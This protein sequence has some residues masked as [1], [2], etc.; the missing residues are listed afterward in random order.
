M[1]FLCTK[2][3]KSKVEFQRIFVWNLKHIFSAQRGNFAFL[4]LTSTKWFVSS[5]F[6][7]Y[8]GVKYNLYLTGERAWV[9][10]H[11]C[12]CTRAR[13]RVCVHE[14]AFTSLRLRVC[15][16]KCALASM[17]PWVCVFEWTC[18]SRRARV[19]VRECAW[20][21]VRARVCSRACVHKPVHEWAC[22]RVRAWV[23]VHACDCVCESKYATDCAY[24]PARVCGCVRMCINWYSDMSVH[25][26]SRVHMG[27]CAHDECVWA[28]EC[29]CASVV[30]ECTYMCVSTCMLAWANAS[31]TAFG[32][33]GPS[34]VW[35]C[36][37]VK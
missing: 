22:T 1:T 29:E 7:K 21:S 30:R 15:V 14:C 23:S 19:C 25:M 9:C 20:A 31:I 34:S 32:R 18:A 27:G 33:V 3:D 12:V 4:Y 17:R 5:D 28:H 26:R 35:S 24:I 6:I 36:V 13:T 16:H 37:A 10:M 2:Y 8:F 11:G